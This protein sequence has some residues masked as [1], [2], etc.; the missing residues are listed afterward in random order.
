MKSLEI[1]F[2]FMSLENTWNQDTHFMTQSIWLPLRSLPDPVT[3]ILFASALM[4]HGNGPLKQLN[5]GRRTWKGLPTNWM[6]CF[7]A[8]SLLVLALNTVSK[9]SFSLCSY[10]CNGLPRQAQPYKIFH[11][12]RVCLS[13]KTIT[14]IRT[15]RKWAFRHSIQV[16][17]E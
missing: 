8:C 5:F 2:D 3:H 4:V 13:W 9:S 7:F 11:F 14:Y 15:E 17:H 6:S 1:A 10:V 16:Q 12:G